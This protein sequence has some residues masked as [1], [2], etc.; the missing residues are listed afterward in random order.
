ME[1]N[2]KVMTSP[3]RW[4]CNAYKPVISPDTTVAP[5][6]PIGERAT[7][8]PQCHAVAGIVCP[9]DRNPEGSL[10]NEEAAL[11]ESFKLIT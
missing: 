11:D 6:G 4:A 1:N 8:G 5:V 7:L 2:G 9:A 3:M 10:K